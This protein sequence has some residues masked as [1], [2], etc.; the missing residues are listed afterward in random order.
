M[1]TVICPLL[2][3]LDSFCMAISDSLL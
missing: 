1:G 3:I 2:V